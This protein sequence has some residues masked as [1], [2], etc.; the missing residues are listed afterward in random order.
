MDPVKS[1]DFGNELVVE[2]SEIS[3]E[4]QLDLFE[5]PIDLTD[6]DIEAGA[7]GDKETREKDIRI[8]KARFDQAVQKERERAAALQAELEAL[9]GRQVKQDKDLQLQEA[10]RQLAALQDQYEDALLEGDKEGA[11]TARMQANQLRDQI[12]DYKSQ[13]AAHQARSSAVQDVQFKDMVATVEETY[14]VLDPDS[15]DYDQDIT[16]EVMEVMDAFIQAGRARAD[17]LA[18]AVGYVFRQAAPV[19][20]APTL[21]REDMARAARLKAVAAAK[22]QP[23]STVKT[24]L[25]NGGGDLDVRTLTPAKFDKLSDEEKA[26]LRGDL[27]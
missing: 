25:D 7:A 27:L 12:Y 8:P 6:G 18:K 1:D 23:P 26:R 3:A 4:D 16:D 24:G 15:E 9:K 2:P 19:A 13:V 22:A 20:A 5:D 14:P 21:T 17:A 11:R 10:E